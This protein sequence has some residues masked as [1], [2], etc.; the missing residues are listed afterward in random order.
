MS[1]TRRMRTVGATLCFTLVAAG[2]FNG[3]LPARELYR[4]SVPPATA[5][6]PAEGPLAGGIEVARY[7]T[8][9]LYGDGNI[10]FRTDEHEY[11]VYPSREWGIPL[12]EMLGLIAQSALDR[13]PLTSESAIYDPPPSH[14]L[15]YLWRGTVREFEEIG[16]G[17]E[18]FV[19]V[20]L[21]VQLIRTTDHV[22][23]WRGSKRIE[24]PVPSPTMA[25]IVAELSAL[26]TEVTDALVAE[27]RASI[28]ARA[29]VSSQP[30]R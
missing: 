2:C 8:P 1:D 22:L 6:A 13:A 3:R 4:L 14:E 19:A 29:A 23:L 26:A 28:A 12:G 11:A 15:P 20:R 18:V 7:V 17:K 21:D 16:R 9:G 27:A 5:A 30:E 24:R 25:A 10:V